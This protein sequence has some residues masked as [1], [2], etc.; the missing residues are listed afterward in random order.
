MMSL[1]SPKVYTF[2]KKVICCHYILPKYYRGKC[3]VTFSMEPSNNCIV[4]VLQ[5]IPQLIARIDSPRRLVSKLIH[6]LLT[7]VG[8]HHPQVKIE[9]NVDTMLIYEYN[10]EL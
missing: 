6:E 7:D 2:R 4:F 10:Y 9:I 1:F 3:L 8:R 5:V